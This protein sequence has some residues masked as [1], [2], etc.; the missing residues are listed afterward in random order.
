VFTRYSL[1]VSFDYT[2]KHLHV[3]GAVKV[4]FFPGAPRLETKV[5]GRTKLLLLLVL[6]NL[7]SSCSPANFASAS[8]RRLF[9]VKR[10]AAKSEQIVSQESHF[11]M[12]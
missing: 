8:V 10:A 6:L 3:V 1:G 7:K 2:V 9:R 11:A 12:S 4:N 5:Y